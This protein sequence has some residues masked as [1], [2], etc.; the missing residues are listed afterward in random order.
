MEMLA[1]HDRCQRIIEDTDAG[2]FRVGMDGCYEDVNPG[3]LRMY[4]FQRKE[5]AIGMRFSAGCGPEDVASAEHL[6]EALMRGEREKLADF[7]RVRQDGS[8]GYHTLSANPLIEEDRVI[9]IEGFIVDISDRRT[10]EHER[11]QSDERYRSLFNFMHEG[12]AVYKLT[13]SGEVP[14]NY[15]VLDVNRRYEEIFGVRRD[16]VMNRLASDVFGSSVAPY[17]KELASAV[18]SKS[19]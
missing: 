15:I 17:L 18:S 12:V 14:D 1:R 11:R 7:C 5:D 10:A 3:W 19:P 2:Y 8:M 6:F 13:Y 4:G 16:E 9:G